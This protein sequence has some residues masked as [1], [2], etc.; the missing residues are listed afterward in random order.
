MGRVACARAAAER[1]SFPHAIRD[2]VRRL[3]SNAHHGA[4]HRTL[5]MAPVHERS[6]RRLSTNAHHARMQRAHTAYAP[7]RHARRSPACTPLTCMHAAHLFTCFICVSL[8]ARRPLHARCSSACATA[9][10]GMR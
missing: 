7:R 5:I 3:P 4:F 1:D 8:V 10:A 9:V 2:G 6:S